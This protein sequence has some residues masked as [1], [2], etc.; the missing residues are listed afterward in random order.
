M[1]NEII[2]AC[3]DVRLPEDLQVEAARLAIEENPANAPAFSFAPSFSVE[4][5]PP[6]FLAMLTGKKWRPGRTLRVMFMDGDPSV[7]DRIPP[8]A[9][10]WSQYANIQFDFGDDPDAEIRI[11]FQ[12]PGSW[13]YMGTD[14]LGRP[15]HK[16][17]MNYGW[18][19]PTS[20]DNEYSRVVTHEFGHALGA[21]H[22][23]QNPG[24]EIPWDK[25][26]VYAYYMGPPNNWSKGQVDWNL[27]HRYSDTITQFSEFDPHSIML[28]P[29]PDKF[30]LGDWEIPWS[31]KVLSTK[32][33]ELVAAV[34]PF[35][36]KE[37]ITLSVDGDPVAAD[38]GQHEEEDWFE[39]TVA[40]AGHYRIETSGWTD[41]IMAL[42]GP[43]SQTELVAQ[44]DDSGFWY[45]ARI[46]AE[47]RP[48]QHFV[49]VKHYRPRGTG[50]YKVSV[51]RQT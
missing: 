48:G 13:S 37:I 22:E 20:P 19:T 31:N 21:I 33:K 11:S 2:K 6:P 42:F 32:D 50:Q 24:A 46:R 7:H 5:P 36:E 43:D 12:H 35:A 10:V 49:R 44:D 47:L 34:Y 15:K 39:F 14:A 25:E 9:H 40:E 18:L 26:A 17:T 28:Y 38:I 41:V 45:N 30:T 23:H 8:F 27:F 3:I 1:T 16:P 29:V 51:R 4:S